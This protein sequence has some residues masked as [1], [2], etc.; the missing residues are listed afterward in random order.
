MHTSGA[1][2][3]PSFPLKREHGLDLASLRKLFQRFKSKLIVTFITSKKITQGLPDCL[4]LISFKNSTSKRY[5][6]IAEYFQ[7][8]VRI[9][10][11]RYDQYMSPFQYWQENQEVLCKSSPRLQ[12]Q[13]I[14][15]K[16]KECTHFCPLILV[17]IVRMYRSKRILDF[18]SGW[19]DRL[20]G[21][22]LCDNF[23]QGYT[24][25]D[26]NPR[27]FTGYKNII[28]NFVPKH[29]AS[30]YTML[31]G[32][33]EDVIPVLKQEY[34]LVITSPPYFDLEEYSSDQKQSTVR[35]KSFDVWYRRFLL[36][37]VQK[38]IEKL[39]ESGVVAINVNN[40]KTHDIMERLIR[41]IRG[42]SY[43]GKVYYGNHR[44]RTSIFQPILIWQKDSTRVAE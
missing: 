17:R 29:S 7:E 42:A 37:S 10:A 1:A 28:K 34:D 4:G 24:G 13:I 35:Y 23:I 31:H 33:A 27:L 36:I 32:C 14:S 11:K 40:Y 5:A 6:N 2:R 30:K 8:H 38:S 16:V 41:D 3:T 20:V 22:C 43:K 26:A 21:A 44:C 19:G 9:D 18:C 25:I 15:R 12:R 39:R